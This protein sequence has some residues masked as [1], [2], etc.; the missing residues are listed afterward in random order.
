MFFNL[1]KTNKDP[2]KDD[3]DS[4]EVL[5]SISFIMTSDSESPIVDVELKD[6]D[7]ECIKAL[8]S[9]IDILAQE[10]SLVETVEIIKN[11]MI[12]D[13]KE[14]Y[15][16]DIFSQISDTTKSKMLN[17][18]EDKDTDEPCVKPSEVFMK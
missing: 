5:A 2:Q 12:K 13:G 16:L 4:S 11:A 7:R 18:Y 8:C 9:L 3:S 14:E 17:A 1:F 10:K 15:L 6:Y